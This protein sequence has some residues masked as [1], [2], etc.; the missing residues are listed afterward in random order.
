MSWFRTPT[1]VRELKRYV[2]RVPSLKKNL[3]WTFM[4]NTVYVFCQWG[5]LAALA[6]L[7]NPEM[8]GQFA[9]GLAVTAPIVLFFN[10]ALRQIQAT[11]ARRQYTFGDYLG[12]RLV[13][14]A[15]ALLAIILVALFAQYSR[16]TALVIVMVGLA[17]SFEAV[18]DVF[19][20]LLQQRERMDRISKSMIIKG[21][22]SL[23]ALVTV[24]YLTGSVLWG[25]ASLAAVWALVLVRYDIGSGMLAL[26]SS[27]ASEGLPLD[28]DRREGLK[29]QWKVRRLASL[30]VL[31]LPLGIVA[32]L[33]SL[34]ANIP[35]YLIEQYLGTR[36]LGI[37]SAMAYVMAAGGAVVAALGQS[38]SARMARY[39]ADG[40]LRAFGTLLS[41]LVGVG[42]L[43]GVMGVLVSAIVGREALAVLYTPEYAEHINVFLWL[44]VAAGL[45]YVA[46][47]LSYGMMSARFFRVQIPLFAG[48]LGVTT[49]AGVV[50]VPDTGILG[51]ALAVV[52]GITFQLAGSIGVL[53][54]ILLRKK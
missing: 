31:A 33:V 23:V 22:L 21:L 38:S 3:S 19:Y 1:E 51:A 17:K 4:G 47:L 11:D 41:K 28:S 5:M 49:L 8:V 15:L 43:F 12:L 45:G 46:I 39:Y 53:V 9:L 42:A 50:L 25:A 13:T 54:Y 10:F 27:H 16:E 52:L 48:V 14:T 34:N 36:E 18:S 35:R 20:G 24:V 32:V 37:F 29:P 44:M 40:D 7:G 26:N 2:S 30:T 6:K